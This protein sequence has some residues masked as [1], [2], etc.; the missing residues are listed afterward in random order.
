MPRPLTAEDLAVLV[1]AVACAF[2]L[3]VDGTLLEIAPR[4]EDVF[5]DET[6]R[7]MLAGLTVACD[8]A[9]ALVSGRRIED[10]DRIFAPSRLV[11]AGLHGAE[12]RFP[13]GTRVAAR[14]TAMDCVRSK[15]QA[16][17]SA[18][19]GARL[20]DKGATLAVH[21]RQRPALEAEV[22]TFL[23]HVAEEG[24]E[25]QPG[26]MVAE[27][28]ESRHDKGKAIET[29]LAVPPFRGRTPVFVGD[30]LTDEA[31]FGFVNKCE[32]LSVRVGSPDVESRARF[33][34]SAPAELRRALASLANAGSGLPRGR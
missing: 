6:L 26:K 5:A 31:G 2:F 10:V 4:P 13:D 24:L 17:V 16:F 18:H 33:S 25:V 1:P 28:K 3:D 22:L 9:L 12:L 30:D 19:E 7:D 34:V 32:G 15:V 23:R 8:G 27:L 11:I 14:S 21:Y 20:E 29:L